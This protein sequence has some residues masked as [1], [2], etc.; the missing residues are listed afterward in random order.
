MARPTIYDETLRDRLLDAAAEI[1]D[2]DGPER[3]SLRDVAASA[4]TST[5]AVYALF[6]GKAELL[7]A[8]IA[9]GF[10]S[11]GA[12]QRAA[13]GAGLRPLGLAYRDWAL[14]HPALY[15]LMF[16]GALS[17]PMPDGRSES[18]SGKDC[19]EPSSAEDA[20]LPLTRAL[21]GTGTGEDSPAVRPEARGDAVAVWAQ[22]HGAVSLELARV[23]AP[24]TDWT[25][26]YERVLD[27]VEASFRRI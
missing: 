16:G 1:V 17:H 24:E 2:R 14:A 27:A 23:A 9:H 18:S 5:S 6:G 3:V 12:S 11:F 13:E 7:A 25:A 4:E 8:V 22:V 21:T 15:R 19:D 20:L 26:V 10:A